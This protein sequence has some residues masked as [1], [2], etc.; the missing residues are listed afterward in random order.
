V[1]ENFKQQQGAS[2]TALTEWTAADVEQLYSR[3]K[4]PGEIEGEGEW[5]SEVDAVSVIALY[6]FHFHRIAPSD[7]NSLRYRADILPA[8]QFEQCWTRADWKK[9]RSAVPN[10]TAAGN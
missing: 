5:E 6:D 3:V 1:G 7:I 10:S 4:V 9:H 8:S 2:N